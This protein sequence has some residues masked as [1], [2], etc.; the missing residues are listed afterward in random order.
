MSNVLT[1]FIDRF[2][3]NGYARWAIRRE[4]NRAMRDAERVKEAAERR[5]AAV[6]QLA[7]TLHV[8]AAELKTPASWT[9]A[10]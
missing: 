2:L 9:S 5:N 4:F 1:R 10:H 7:H 3:P 6:A 8:D